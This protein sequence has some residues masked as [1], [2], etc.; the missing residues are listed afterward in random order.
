MKITFEEPSNVAY[1]E[2]S[3]EKVNKTVP[4]SADCFVDVDEDGDII[5][6]EVIDVQNIAF[7]A[8]SFADKFG[9]SKELAHIVNAGIEK[10][11]A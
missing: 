9:V 8:N 4:F 3:Y 5:G 11:R 6:V 2:L 10:L 7:D 1:L